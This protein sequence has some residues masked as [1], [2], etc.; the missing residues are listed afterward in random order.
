MNKVHSIK[1]RMIVICS[2][3]GIDRMHKIFHLRLMVWLVF[4]IFFI[5]G[6]ASNLVNQWTVR[7]SSTPFSSTSNLASV[8]NEVV[9]LLPPLTSPTLRENE[10]GLGIYLGGAIK[11]IFPVWKVIEEQQT[12]GLINRYELVNEYAILRKGAEQNHIL[13][14]EVLRKIGK[15]IGARYVFQPRL[16]YILQTMTNRWDMPF[17]D[18]R[19]MQT[20][21]AHIR[22]SLQLWDTV[23]GELIWSSAAETA[24]ESEA[25]TQDPIFVEDVFRVT[26]DG[27]LK[28]LKNKKISS[29]YT[30]LN[31]FYNGFSIDENDSELRKE[32]KN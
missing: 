4:I 22:L 27:M 17:F 31:Q 15:K 12:I 13:D 8:V 23:S 29:K 21:S 32:S 24:V 2:Y 10:A 14:R 30:R 16:A 6:C 9:L 1:V 11:K 25:I 18:I 5:T 28:D 26:L 20:R 19:I 7:T 3:K